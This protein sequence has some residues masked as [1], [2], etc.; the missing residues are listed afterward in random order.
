MNDND[1]RYKENHVDTRGDNITAKDSDV[2]KLFFQNINCF[3]VGEKGNKSELIQ[4]L[5]MNN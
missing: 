4:K 5:M 3:I 1:G 2:I